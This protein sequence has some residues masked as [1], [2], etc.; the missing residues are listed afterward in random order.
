MITNKEKCRDCGK[1]YLRFYSITDDQ[2]KPCP[3]CERENRISLLEENVDY[4]S[5]TE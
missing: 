5:L 2:P 4:V 1:V 3:Y